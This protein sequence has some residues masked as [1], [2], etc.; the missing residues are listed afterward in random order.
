MSERKSQSQPQTICIE[1]VDIPEQWFIEIPEIAD[2]V[3]E[4]TPIQRT[5]LRIAISHLKT[6]FD[7]ARSNGFVEW[8]SS[9]SAESR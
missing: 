4:M 1:G 3:Y 8:L 5:A 9:R 2:Y 6:S 7:F